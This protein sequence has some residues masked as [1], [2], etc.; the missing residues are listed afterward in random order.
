MPAS[1][2]NS[3]AAGRETTYCPNGAIADL[4]FGRSIRV[5]ATRRLQRRENCSNYGT[6]NVEGRSSIAYA[7][8]LY[9]EQ[10]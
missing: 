10:L 9:F 3:I 2:I 1:A 4:S 8:H 7:T 6:V 5:N